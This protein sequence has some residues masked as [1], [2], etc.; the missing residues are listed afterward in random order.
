MLADR[1]K[2]MQPIAYTKNLIDLVAVHDPQT[3]KVLF[4]L[5]SWEQ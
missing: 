2:S 3:G 5:E 4:I 1:I